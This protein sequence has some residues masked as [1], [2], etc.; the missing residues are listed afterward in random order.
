M[1]KFKIVSQS[2]P[3]ISN[4][5]YLSNKNIHQSRGEGGW[6]SEITLFSYLWGTF[7]LFWVNL[8]VSFQIYTIIS[9]CFYRILS[10]LEI[11]TCCII[12]WWFQFYKINFLTKYV[13]YYRVILK[14]QK[15]RVK[16]PTVGSL[17]RIPPRLVK[18]QISRLL[19]EVELAY[20]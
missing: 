4:F 2:H 8:P 12:V 3:I 1:S 20:G 18:T 14:K 11:V 7:E 15:K 9:S 16:L 19:T 6:L 17:S 10:Y 13:V 5:F